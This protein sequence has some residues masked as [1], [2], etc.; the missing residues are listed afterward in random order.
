MLCPQVRPNKADVK[1]DQTPTN[2]TQQEKQQVQKPQSPITINSQDQISI[3]ENKSYERTLINNATFDFIRQKS[4]ERQKQPIYAQHQNSLN[5]KANNT[6]TMVNE[7]AND[8]T[9]K[10][11][12]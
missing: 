7:L 11:V 6:H 4:P 12:E 5:N 1:T 3:K 10:I 9:L 8:A 2:E